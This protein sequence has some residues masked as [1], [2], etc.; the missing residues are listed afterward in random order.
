MTTNR[1]Y[2]CVAVLATLAFGG[3]N[4]DH[5]I[6]VTK[7]MTWECAPD[8]KM[9][10]YPDAQPVRLRFVEDPQFEDVV[11]GRGLCDQLKGAGKRE[12]DVGFEVWGNCRRGMNGYR[13]V[14]VDGKPI[15]DIGGWASSGASGRATGPHPLESVFKCNSP[16]TNRR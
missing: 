1:Y 7:K 14:T 16:A 15:V 13:E 9:P 12:V 2:L 8:R 3:C 5:T 6:R 11:S 10:Q 4:R